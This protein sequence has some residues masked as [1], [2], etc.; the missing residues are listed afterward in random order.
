MTDRFDLEQQILGCW[1]IIDEIKL[2]TEQVLENDDFDKDKISNFLIG[3]ETIYQLK[4]DHLFTTFETL[5]QDRKN[6]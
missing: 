1:G 3:L 4:F 2:L 6:V 5:V